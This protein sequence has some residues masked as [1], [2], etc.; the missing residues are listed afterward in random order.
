MDAPTLTESIAYSGPPPLAGLWCELAGICAG[1]QGDWLARR[2]MARLDALLYSAPGM[3]EFRNQNPDVL[4][5]GGNDQHHLL[6]ILETLRDL[7]A[8]EHFRPLLAEVEKK[9]M[10]RWDIARR[11]AG[12]VVEGLR[13]SSTRQ[14]EKLKRAEFAKK[15]EVYL[16]LNAMFHLQP[17][18]PTCYA[19]LGEAHRDKFTQQQIQAEAHPLFIS[20]MYAYQQEKGAK[21]LS[22]YRNGWL[23]NQLLRRLV[24]HL[25]DDR[26]TDISLNQPVTSGKG[27]PASLGDMVPDPRSVDPHA[28]A[29]IGDL[30]DRLRDL[31]PRKLRPREAEVIRLRFGLPEN[32]ERQP[33]GGE[34]IHPM[35]LEEIG[36]T[37]AI[38]RERVRQIEAQA[39]GKLVAAGAAIRRDLENNEPVKTNGRTSGAS[40]PGQGAGMAVLPR[41]QAPPP[42]R[43]PAA[44]ACA[45]QPPLDAA[46]A[47]PAE[48]AVIRAREAFAAMP[49]YDWKK[50]QTIAADL[51]TG[52]V[53][54]VQH[55]NVPRRVEE[56]SGNGI[57][58]NSVARWLDDR[59]TYNTD[60][61][62]NSAGAAPLVAALLPPALQD[63]AASYLVGMPWQGRA[64]SLHQK[65]ETAQR[66]GM[67][68]ACFMRLLRYGAHLSTRK[69]AEHLGID[70]SI[71]SNIS[72]IT[73]EGQ[74]EPA[75]NTKAPIKP[76]LDAI[77]HALG[78]RP[79]DGETPPLAEAREAHAAIFRK[80]VLGIPHHVTQAALEARLD[81]MDSAAAGVAR[82]QQLAGFFK[83]LR[84]VHGLRDRK[85]LAE[86]AAAH[87]G[88][89]ENVAR[90]FQMRIH[91]ICTPESEIGRKLAEVVC[92]HRT[93]HRLEDNAAAAIAGFAFPHDAARQAAC[94]ALLAQE[95]Q[96]AA[97]SHVAQV[98]RPS[99]GDDLPPH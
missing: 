57:S 76:K 59:A 21:F 33:P 80:M 69:Y 40:A 73:P 93:I 58:R 20:A 11:D 31:I 84:E 72:P 97:A 66:L 60:S 7:S 65:L 37:L 28:H 12:I 89:G 85:E 55:A 29:E 78:L 82:A 46:P 38:T 61:V 48:L 87:A 43:L 50:A 79:Q 53:R 91:D 18:M 15:P 22:Y 8:G 26:Q 41:L 42:P 90:Q 94:K 98:N 52:L 49:R 47:T 35:T 56:L 70:P 13:K 5:R 75:P 74:A 36:R 16:L 64:T 92:K 34:P 1:R 14:A 6:Y 24:R 32:F 3:Q 30:W 88:L 68:G 10:D 77:A 83:T 4:K 23:E 9:L 27:D 44:P 86:A 17:I 19:V 71:L 62:A 95:R 39:L 45:P 25:E 51:F 67:D 99:G 2:S 54:T 63:E 96:H 81:A